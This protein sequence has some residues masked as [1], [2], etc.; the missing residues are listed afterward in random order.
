LAEQPLKSNQNFS[1]TDLR[2]SRFVGTFF[3]N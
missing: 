2:Q 1:S 3:D